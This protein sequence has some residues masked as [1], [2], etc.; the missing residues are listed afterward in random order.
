MTNPTPRQ[1]EFIADIEYETGI[2]FTGS[3]KQEASE[4]IDAK[5]EYYRDL[6]EAVTESTHGGWGNRDD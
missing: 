4:Y 2:Q 6:I 1:L 3:T 5:I